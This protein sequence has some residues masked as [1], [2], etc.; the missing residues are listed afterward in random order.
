MNALCCVKLSV[1]RI[2]ANAQLILEQSVGGALD[3]LEIGNDRPDN[4]F[5]GRRKQIEWSKALHARRSISSG[6]LSNRLR[7]IL[8]PL[9]LVRVS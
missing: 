4:E 7:R 3:R 5:G 2:V 1:V 9:Q 6:A 8:F